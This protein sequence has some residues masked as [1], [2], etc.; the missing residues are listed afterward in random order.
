MVFKEGVVG[1][2][3]PAKRV[4]EDAKRLLKGLTLS[5][6]VGVLFLVLCFGA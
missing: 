6:G 5:L 1:R 2:N 4:A 3:D